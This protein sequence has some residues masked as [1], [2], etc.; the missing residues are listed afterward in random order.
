MLFNFNNSAFMLVILP[1][2][3][4]VSVKEIKLL[5]KLAMKDV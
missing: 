5:E 4:K 3:W 2:K 1:A